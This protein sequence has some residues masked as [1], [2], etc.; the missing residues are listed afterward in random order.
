VVYG[1]GQHLVAA[2]HLVDPK[3][4]PA[5][6][7]RL[8]EALHVPTDIARRSAAQHLYDPGGR[9]RAVRGEEHGLHDGDVGD[10][11][12]ARRLRR[13]LWGRGFGGFVHGGDHNGQRR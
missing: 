11:R 5:L 13:G 4:G 8:V 3:R 9:Q 12:L 7:I 2:R 10:L 6:P 1:Q